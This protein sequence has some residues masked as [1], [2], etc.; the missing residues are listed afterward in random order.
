MKVS[1]V[2]IL[3]AVAAAQAQ[4]RPRPFVPRMTTLV[5]ASLTPAQGL[6]TA[7]GLEGPSVNGGR[8]PIVRRPMT[9]E[10]WRAIFP[11]RPGEK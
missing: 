9:E 3:A 10:E 1:I 6:Q 5:G 4:E 2:L 8:G 7:A 11:K